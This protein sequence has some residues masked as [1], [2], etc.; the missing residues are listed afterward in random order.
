MK[1]KQAPKKILKFLA[2]TA[3]LGIVAIYWYLQPFSRYI[4]TTLCSQDGRPVRIIIDVTWQRSLF[5]PTKVT[6]TVMLDGTV[7]NSVG[8]VMY[9]DGSFFSKLKAKFNPGQYPYI[10]FRRKPGTEYF[11]WLYLDYAGGDLG[12]EDSLG[13]SCQTNLYGQ[14]G[15]YYYG[16]ARNMDEVNALLAKRIKNWTAE[17]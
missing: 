5:S 1:N 15:N 12:Q 3:I 7:Y 16:P 13:I 2:L 8:N 10:F 4:A 17:R 9:G 11:D 6:G 14:N